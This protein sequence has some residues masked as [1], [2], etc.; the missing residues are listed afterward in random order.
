MDFPPAAAA[1][2]CAAA[3]KAPNMNKLNLN[4]TGAAAAPH[5]DIWSVP[6]RVNTR[7]LRLPAPA[8][9]L[10]VPATREN[11]ERLRALRD[12]ESLAWTVGSP[13]AALRAEVQN[14]LAGQ[15]TES[16]VFTAVGVMAGVTLI[17][18]AASA[19]DFVTNWRHFVSIVQ[20]ALG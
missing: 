2:K 19:L 12:A 20:T 18:G 3:M 15:R 14:S 11:R 6:A 10:R 1:V 5:P 4:L 9:S 16:W 8:P 7:R 13:T 17:I